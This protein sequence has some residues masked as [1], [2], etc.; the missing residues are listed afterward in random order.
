MGLTLSTAKDIADVIAFFERGFTV[1][2]AL[3]L[4]EAFKQFVNEKAQHGKEIV[5]WSCLPALVS[6]LFLIF[7][8]FQGMSRYFYMS[9]GDH[10]QIQNLYSINVMVDSIFFLTEL[11]IFFIMSRAL[12][13]HLCRRF[14]IWSIILAI[15]DLLW[16]VILYTIFQKRGMEYWMLLDVIYI[17]SISILLIAKPQPQSSVEAGIG[18]TIVIARTFLD[19]YF[20]WSFYFPP[21]T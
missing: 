6:F 21:I 18:L 5:N 12:S 7:P 9:Y 15:T 4:G 1:V 8:F 3:A 19:Y 10:A 13:L 17:I 20:N 16:S 2:L 14:Y 11:A